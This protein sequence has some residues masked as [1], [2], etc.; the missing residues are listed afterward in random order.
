MKKCLPQSPGR[1][2]VASA[3]HA[4]VSRL[5]W[6]D[7]GLSRLG[8]VTSGVSLQ[9]AEIRLTERP[10]NDIFDKAVVE[11]VARHRSAYFSGADLPR[12]E[13]LLHD[14]SDGIRKKQGTLARQREEAPLFNAAAAR[15]NQSP[16]A[17]PSDLMRHPGPLPMPLM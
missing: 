12:I 1:Q 6:H 9:L 8:G 14:T 3:F 7:A 5:S 17:R 2:F 11:L 13:R 16:A 15:R 4:A 10:A